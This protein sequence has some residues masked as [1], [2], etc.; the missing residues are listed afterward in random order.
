MADFAPTGEVTRLLRAHHA[1]DR[2]AFET[3][4]EL[5]YDRLR[6]IARGQIR[7]AGRR[8][9]LDT[10]ALVHDAYL[11]LVDETG[12]EWQNHSHF[13][14]ICARAMR[15]ILVDY[16]RKRTALKRGGGTPDL[17]LEPEML[18]VE[19]QAELVLAVDRALDCL[20]AL[21]ERLSRVVE[22][23]FFAGMTVPETAEALESSV[24]TVERDWKRARAWLRKELE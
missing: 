5:V 23:R 22:C 8:H 14:A 9:T 4:V 1:G 3:L 10:G 15:R 12:V 21:D 13:Y 20:D 19:D 6:R 18:K 7:R 17:T 16:S 2:A 24:R 11:Q